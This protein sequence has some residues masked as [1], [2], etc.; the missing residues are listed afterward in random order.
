MEINNVIVGTQLNEIQ[1]KS[2]EVKLV[3]QNQQS[4]KCYALTFNGLL[5][6][7]SGSALNKRVKNIQFDNTLGF[8]AISQLRHL[9]KDPHKYRQIFIQMEG[10][11]DNNKMELLAAFSDYKLSH[12]RRTAPSSKMPGNNPT[13][14]T[15]KKS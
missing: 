1:K 10:S 6:E 8:R 2:D 14:K 11:D 13:R 5:F 15:I 12:V 7:T 9:N 3:F 4:K